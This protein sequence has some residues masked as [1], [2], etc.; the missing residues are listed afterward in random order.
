MKNMTYIIA[1]E[2]AIETVTDEEVKNKLKALKEQIQKKNSA[3]RKPTKTQVANEGLKQEIVQFLTE[4]KTATEV[5]EQFNISV[6]KATALLTA[7]KQ[8]EKVVRVVEKRKA[9][10]ISA[11]AV[12]E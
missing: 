1:L 2:V 6:N 4:R 12:T 11:D 7:L 5:A 3:D 10:Y 9:F 8:D